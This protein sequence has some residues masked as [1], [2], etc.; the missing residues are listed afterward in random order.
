VLL[1]ASSMRGGGSELQTAMLARHLERERF[2][3]HLYLTQAVS[4][5]RRRGMWQT[6]WDG[7]LLAGV[8]DWSPSKFYGNEASRPGSTWQWRPDE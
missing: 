8:R 3:V 6:G 2:D 5:T 1:M 4:R 7:E